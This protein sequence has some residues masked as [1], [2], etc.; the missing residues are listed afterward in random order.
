MRRFALH[1]RFRLATVIIAVASLS[2]VLGVSGVVQLGFGF[3]E[4]EAVQVAKDFLMNSPTFRFDGLADSVKI[5][6]AN[7]LDR[8]S[9]WRIELGFTC[10]HAGYGDR[11]GMILLMVLTNHQISLV[12]QKGVLE[13]A[14]IDD[15]WDELNQIWLATLKVTTDKTM[16]E[17]ED[18]VTV[19]I[20]N[21]TDQTVKF[22]STAYGVSFDKWQEDRWMLHYSVAGAE[23]IVTLEPKKATQLTVEPSKDRPFTPG[24]YRVVSTGWIEEDNSTLQV[25]GHSEFTVQ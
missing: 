3:T 7:T 10:R 11:T 9:T 19:T 1:P 13:S 22:G 20:K 25:V 12:V 23:V 2:L 14:V 16:Y 15:V 18:N 24:Q 5:V 21:T 4:E 17:E 8:P 6:S